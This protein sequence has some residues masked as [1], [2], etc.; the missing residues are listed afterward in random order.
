MKK[1]RSPEEIEVFIAS[2]HKVKCDLNER[3]SGANNFSK[4]LFKFMAAIRLIRIGK[5]E[6]GFILFRLNQFHGKKYWSF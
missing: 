1:D 5:T 3:M 4:S 6:D 2:I